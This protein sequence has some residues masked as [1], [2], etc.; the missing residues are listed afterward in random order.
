MVTP[1]QTWV[2]A[3]LAP[4][5]STRLAAGTACLGSQ[6]SS[7]S[8]GLYM[9]PFMPP[10]AFSASTAVNKPACTSSPYWVLGPVMGMGTPIRMGSAAWA[11]R[12]A[13]P[14]RAAA[15]QEVL[16][17]MNVLRCIE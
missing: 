15:A 2:M 11:P 17:R 13:V 10:A 4:E 16:R 1:E 7:I 9:R 12:D 14:S 6:A 8:T 3:N 5:L